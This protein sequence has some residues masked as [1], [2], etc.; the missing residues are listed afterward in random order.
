MRMRKKKVQNLRAS[1]KRKRN[2][3]IKVDDNNGL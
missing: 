1:S 2:N 3:L